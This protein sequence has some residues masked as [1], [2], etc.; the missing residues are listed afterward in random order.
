MAETSEKESSNLI[1]KTEKHEQVIDVSLTQKPTLVDKE[2]DTQQSNVP[3]LVTY[4]C[5]CG[6]SDCLC[7]IDKTENKQE[8]SNTKTEQNNMQSEDSSSS[9][10]INDV[11]ITEGTQ[12]P[13]CMETSKEKIVSYLCSVHYQIR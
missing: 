11:I 7:N 9:S 5:D 10:C 2:K 3:K 4:H 6:H 1:T 13:E 12:C 8:S